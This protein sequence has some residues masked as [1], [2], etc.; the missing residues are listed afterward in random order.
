MRHQFREKSVHK[1]GINI[2]IHT[3]FSL[4]GSQMLP[5]YSA[6]DVAKATKTLFCPHVSRLARNFRTLVHSGEKK[7]TKKTNID[8]LSLKEPL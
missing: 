3:R 2:I 4:P 7:K 5:R 6:S 8:N 1:G